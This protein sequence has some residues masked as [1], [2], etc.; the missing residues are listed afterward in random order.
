MEFEIEKMAADCLSETLEQLESVN[1]K[2]YII[3]KLTIGV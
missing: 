2:Y 1:I 3:I